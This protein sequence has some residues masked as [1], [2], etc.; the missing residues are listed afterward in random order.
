MFS[1]AVCEWSA[2]FCIHNLL[3]SR[4][5]QQTLL[6]SLF[7]KPDL[8]NSTALHSVTCDGTA[9]A[10]VDARTAD[11]AAA[12]RGLARGARA[13]A[14]AHRCRRPWKNLAACRLCRRWKD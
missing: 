6:L 5:Y 10:R 7:M 13:H 12:V 11:T 8:F 2:Y 4:L 1:V 9:D 3:R 14:P